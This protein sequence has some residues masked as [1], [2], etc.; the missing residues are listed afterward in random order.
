MSKGEE[1]EK[2]LAL[3]EYFGGGY[4]ELQQLIS[5]CY[6]LK[7]INSLKPMSV[8]EIGK[9]NGF[10]SSFLELSGMDVT[11]VDINPNL[12]PDIISSIHELPNILHEKKFD[13][14]VC[15][16]VLEH[17][18]FKEFERCLIIFLNYSK[19]LYLT[20][21]QYRTWFGFSGFLRIP[22][23]NIEINFGVHVKKQ[24]KL[25]ANHVHFWEVDFDNE[26]SKENILKII[27]EHY[28]S[29]ESGSFKLNKY[30]E[31]FICNN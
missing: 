26:T 13:L 23:K 7:H 12:R 18:E 17:L 29:V 30:H 6:Q 15:C 1:R 28:K 24:K 19:N 8:L 27:G 20:L 11:T 25:D 22:K 5:M 2:S 16:E 14:V 21:P 10:V 4:F 31:F 9:G 3:E